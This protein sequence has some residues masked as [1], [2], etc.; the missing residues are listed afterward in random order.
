VVA[1][2]PSQ[3]ELLRSATERCEKRK[4]GRVRTHSLI[5]SDDLDEPE[6]SLERRTRG[7]E[8]LEELDPL[9]AMRDRLGEL[10]KRDGGV[11]EIGDKGSSFGLVKGEAGRDSKGRRSAI[12][13]ER[14]KVVSY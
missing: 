9:K 5:G 8:H 13:E 3:Q 14:E 7:R 1:D 4:K 10:V 11:G 6:C 2:G 12:A